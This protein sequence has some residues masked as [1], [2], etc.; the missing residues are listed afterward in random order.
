VK[1]AEQD[2]HV[3]RA[4]Y[5]Y[6]E[7]KLRDWGCSVELEHKVAYVI[8][9]QEQNGFRLN[10]NKAQAL[11]AEL[12]QEL[13]DIERE[14]QVIFP[15]IMVPQKTKGTALVTPKVSNRKNRLSRGG[16]SVLARQGPGRSTPALKCRLSV[17]C[18]LKYKW[19]PRQFTATGRA[20]VDEK[21]LSALPYAEVK[22]L[23]RYLR[24]S[25][26]LGQLADGDNA[27]L[28]LVKPD[29]RVYG[30]VNTIGCA[31][32]RMSHFAPNMGQVDKKDLRMR[33][34][35]EPRDRAGC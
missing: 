19:R 13:T 31:T 34:V 20:K 32:G 10:L 6:V 9:L 3:T 16:V 25:K 4:L 1:Y 7:P 21:V 28:K 24:V 8:G 26:Q 29:G 35:W 17:G 18:K 14:L 22:P 27:W 11:E 2:I 12:R 23:L 30:A 33:E 5:R 15:P